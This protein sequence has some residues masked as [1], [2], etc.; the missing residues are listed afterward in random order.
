MSAEPRLVCNVCHR[1]L[2]AC[3]QYLVRF[4]ARHGAT[5]VH[6]NLCFPPARQAVAK[7]APRAAA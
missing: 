7:P 4:D 2:S 6:R 1:P 3:D 5:V